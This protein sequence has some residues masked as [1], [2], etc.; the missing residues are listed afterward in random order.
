M[1]HHWGGD[2]ED[3]YA[4]GVARVCVRVGDAD[5]TAEGA[6]AAEAKELLDAAVVAVGRLRT[7]IQ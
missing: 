5:V 6:T 1:G 4:V 2:D 7:Q 3:G